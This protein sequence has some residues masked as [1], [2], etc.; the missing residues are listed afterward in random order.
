MSAH[1][2]MRRTFIFGHSAA[3]G[4][5][6]HGGLAGKARRML[7][8]KL[9]PGSREFSKDNYKVTHAGDRQ[10]AGVRTE[11]AKDCEAYGIGGRDWRSGFGRRGSRERGSGR[12][13][14]ASVEPSAGR[15]LRAGIKDGGTRAG[16]G[17]GA[18]AS[19][20]AMDR[21]RR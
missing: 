19:R 10:Q 13:F 17:G 3:G 21:V 2:L 8:E 5:C 9:Q 1:S 4:F 14:G 6:C 7:T 11:R 16:V 15:E 12:R 20:K 18:Q